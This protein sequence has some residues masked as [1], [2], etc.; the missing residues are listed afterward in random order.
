MF[1]GAAALTVKRGAVTA[2]AAA[3]G[4][5]GSIAAGTSEG[6]VIVW[7]LPSGASGPEDEVGPVPKCEF[8]LL[9][10][11]HMMPFNQQCCP[12]RHSPRV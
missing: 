12:S 2:V 5:G 6:E 9:A 10:P 1:Q 4:F 11:R 8:A 7:R 3:P